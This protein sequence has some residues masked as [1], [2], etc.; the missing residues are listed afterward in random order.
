MGRRDLRTRG[1]EPVR[2]IPDPRCRLGG[3]RCGRRPWSP[4]RASASSATRSPTT[5]RRHLSADQVAQA[6]ARRPVGEQHH[7]R[8]TRRRADHHGRAAGRRRGHHPHVPDGGWCGDPQLLAGRR[9]RRRG[10]ARTRASTV[11]SEPEH[12]NG[13][14]VEFESDGHESRVDAW[15]DAGPQVERRETRRGRGRRQPRSRAPGTT[16]AVAVVRA[17]VDRWASSGRRAELRPSNKFPRVGAL[18][19]GL[20][21]GAS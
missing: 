21:A 7:D 13:V 5:G 2:R 15:W 6:V 12:G 17:R 1:Y 9:R 19:R 18:R 10:D 8:P 4:G 3:G 20:F 11:D 16:A 14:K